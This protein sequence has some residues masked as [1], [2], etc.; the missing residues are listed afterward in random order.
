MTERKS[1]PLPRVCLPPP[2]ESIQGM[3]MA[4]PDSS[5]RP[6]RINAHAT[7]LQCRLFL[8]M[9]TLCSYDTQPSILSHPITS[10]ITR[11]ASGEADSKRTKLTPPSGAITISTL[12]QDGSYDTLQA[13]VK[14]VES[15][16][17]EI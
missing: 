7:D 12:V 11:S 1:S 6:S 10:S 14:D 17:T 9:L 3:R 2:V 8:C 13:L 16:A 15:A 4:W 5:K